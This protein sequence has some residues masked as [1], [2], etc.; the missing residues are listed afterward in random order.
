MKHLR[1]ALSRWTVRL[2]FPVPWSGP[3]TPSEG[4]MIH[5]KLWHKLLESRRERANSQPSAAEGERRAFIYALCEFPEAELLAQMGWFSLDQNFLSVEGNRI[6]RGF[7]FHKS[8]QLGQNDNGYAHIFHSVHSHYPQESL[9]GG[10][11][12]KIINK[13]CFQ[14]PYDVSKTIIKFYAWNCLKT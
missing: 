6:Y 4:S 13:H 3:K 8:A 10:S 2:V 1:G 14:P 5:E 9:D 7:V 12:V 11:W